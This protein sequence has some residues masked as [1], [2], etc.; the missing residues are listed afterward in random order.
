VVDDEA[1]IRFSLTELLGSDG[2]TVH[3]AEHAPA[4]LAAMEQCE[5][6]LVF[7]DLRMPAIDGLD[8]LDI[9]RRYHSGTLVVLMTAYGDE[10]L[11]VRALKGGA[12]DYIPKPFDNDEIRAI[13]SR[14][15]EVLALRRENDRLRREIASDFRGLI[16]RCPPMVAVHDLIMRAGPTDATVLVVGESGTG[17]ELVARAL[18]AENG[19]RT[20]PFVALNCSALPVDL[21]EAELFGHVR[22]A[23]TG[24]VRDRDGVFASAHGGTLFLDEIGD[25]A[26]GAQA[27]LLRALEIGEIIPVGSNKPVS[28]DVRIV[29]ATHRSLDSLVREGNFREDL[30]Y[31]LQ[32]ITI[33]VPPLRARRED[34]PP[35]AIHF[36]AHFAD[37]YELP[38]RTLTPEARCALLAHDWPGNVRELRNVLERAIVLA[39]G[40]E[41]DVDDLPAILSSRGP[42][43]PPSEAVVAELSFAQARDRAV[44]EYDR[45]FL[46]AALERYEGNVSRTARAI[47]MHRQ[48][49]QKLMAKLGLRE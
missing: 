14:S 15:A 43:L 36:L 25:L 46:A 8:L 4:A 47:G 2:H 21:V 35:L 9:V 13:V 32:V 31:R 19:R 41:I 6:D 38:R 1:S 39:T 7:T 3:S 40:D 20:R 34:I 30:L 5:P 24:A 28:A 18:H 11:A 49:L 42:A 17:K 12:Y 23:F 27:K 44:R 22:G 16:G 48:T 26:L 45:N 33:D 29:A 10:R 37:K